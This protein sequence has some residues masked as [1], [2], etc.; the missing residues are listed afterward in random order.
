MLR[1]ITV[2][3]KLMPLRKPAHSRATSEQHQVEDSS[4]FTLLD[5][6]RQRLHHLPA[7]DQHALHNGF[8]YQL[9]ARQKDTAGSDHK[10]AKHKYR[11]ALSKTNNA[12]KI[13]FIICAAHFG[14]IKQNQ[15]K[16][17]SSK[18]F[19]FKSSN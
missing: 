2:V 18:C 13:H 5:A 8:I 1:T 10:S 9:C 12:I 15:S 3:S 6:E 4:F 14:Q 19:Y 17:K 11:E 16:A 7:D